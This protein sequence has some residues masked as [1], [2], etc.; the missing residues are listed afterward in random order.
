[1]KQ[2]KKLPLA[3]QGA[4]F[5]NTVRR[6]FMRLCFCKEV[7]DMKKVWQF[8]KRESVLSAAVLLALVS[9]FFVPPDADYW[10]YID[11]HTLIVL[12]S[13]MT[14][15]ALLRRQGVF[16]RLG[17]ALLSRTKSLLQILFVLVGL[18]FFGSMFITNDVS[19]LTFV[20]FTFVVLENLGGDALRRLAVP[21]V[22]MQ[23]V[24]ANLGSML[25][26]IG[27]PQN[28]YLFGKS[29]MSI[30]EFIAL[31]LPYSLASLVL[32]VVWCIALGRRSALTETGAA[33][34]GT[35]IPLDAKRVALYALLFLVCLLAVM[36]IV[37][38]AAVLALVLVCAL[39]ADRKAVAE[40][41]YSLLLTFVA[42]FVFIGNLGR[43][44]AFSSWLQ[45]ILAG[46]E[47]LAAV[48]A[49]QVTSN[50][51]AALLLSGFTSET[52]ALIIGTNLGG[53]GTLIASMASLI[54]YRKIARP[55]PDTKGRYFRTFTVS[56]ILFL[57]ALL[58]LWAVIG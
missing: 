5:Y 47:V 32:L 34:D 58:G 18:C 56:N 2:Q 14:V 21:T 48:I 25:T 28:L 39:A 52:E 37:P 38:D 7:I 50:V 45:S 46:H 35:E 1:M 23:T 10:D 31:M 11:R 24:A 9:A 44:P 3:K 17:R 30:G 33:P 41:D 12:F 20:P 8:I 16:E 26:P 40:V 54:S 42:F 55:L 43:I 49:S 53:L 51:P 57:A 29:G 27:N 15:M 6:D 19:L 13:L 36:R 22:C 4:T